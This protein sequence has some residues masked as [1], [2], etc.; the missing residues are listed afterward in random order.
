MIADDPIFALIERHRGA[1]RA[2]SAAVSNKD[3]VQAAHWPWSDAP[4]RIAADAQYDAASDAR[5]D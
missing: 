1:T 2:F 4:E 3:R 5:G